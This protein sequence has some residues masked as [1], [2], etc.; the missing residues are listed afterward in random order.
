MADIRKSQS[1]RASLRRSIEI[2]I[3]QALDATAPLIAFLD[4][5][6]GDAEAEDDGLAE[7]ML[8]A[9]ITGD[10]QTRW[11]GFAGEAA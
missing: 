6:D 11:A 10:A 8:A 9:L 7:P 3:E 4:D 5:L 1:G 2:A